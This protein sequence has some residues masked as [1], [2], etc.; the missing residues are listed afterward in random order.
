M[1]PVY[2]I[3][4][5][6]IIDNS[7]NLLFVLVKYYIYSCRISSSLPSLTGA[8]NMLKHSYNIEKLSVSFYKSPGVR[9][10][11]ELKWNVIKNALN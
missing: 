10:K 5:S 6:D 2:I 1:S 11:I 9:E 3:L 4:G 7:I 8:L